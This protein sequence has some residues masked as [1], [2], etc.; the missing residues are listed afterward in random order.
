MSW[1]PL[2]PS[3]DAHF[4]RATCQLKHGS[5][6]RYTI[7]YHDEPASAAFIVAACA[8]MDGQVDI[9]SYWVFSD[10]FE[11]GGIIAA[12]FHGGF[13]LMTIHGTPKPAYRAFQLLHEAGMKRLPVK[14][15]CPFFEHC[16]P[17]STLAAAAADDESTATAWQHPESHGLASSNRCTDTQNNTAGGVLATY[18]GTTLRLFLYNHPVL[19]A[20][21]GIDCKM[22]V[23]LSRS[24]FSGSALLSGASYA[25]RIDETHTNPKAAFK[26][27]G[28]PQYPTV[29]QLT[30]LEK[31]SELVWMSL[32]EVGVV[33]GGSGLTVTVP[34]NGLVVVDV[35][36]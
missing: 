32:Q 22:T 20:T 13:G 11:E 33:V 7:Q 12:P 16:D 14:G 28:Q 35:P 10:V 15:A 2:P 24:G 31:A 3:S 23:Q 5:S 9:S 27:M 21:A 36:Q 34:A 1:C 4:W 18:N 26:Q 8:G 6:C 30:T 25:T 17:P 19:S 29:A